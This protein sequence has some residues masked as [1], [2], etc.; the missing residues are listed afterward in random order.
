VWST[1]VA[2][3]P[4]LALALVTGCADVSASDAPPASTVFVAALEDAREGA[5]SEAQLASLQQAVVDGALE[6]EQV[7]EAARLTISC[8]EA[9]GLDAR[10]DETT[11]SH[12]VVVPGYLVEHG[13]G[14][15]VDA[16]VESCDEREFHWVSKAYQLQPSSV[17]AAERFVEQ[18]APVIRACLEESGIVTRTRDTGHDLAAKASHVMSESGG[19]V[20]CLA[21]AGVDVW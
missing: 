10:Y 17:E 16:E 11:M 12:G 5:A 13:P 20:N 14:Q 2:W 19:A 9:A 21:E 4:C 18:R 15:D 6:I 1:R 3:F 8:M 7:R